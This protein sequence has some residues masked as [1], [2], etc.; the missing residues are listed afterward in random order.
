MCVKA[1]TILTVQGTD[2]DIPK[3]ESVIG[4]NRLSPHENTL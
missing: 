1:E 3:L 4:P 2:F